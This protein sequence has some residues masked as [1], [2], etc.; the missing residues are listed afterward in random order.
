MMVN[1]RSII[2]FYCLP[3]LLP[4]MS[5]Q[6]CCMLLL[7]SPHEFGLFLV[8][9]DLLADSSFCMVV[10]SNRTLRRDA[11]WSRA[12]RNFRYRSA[13]GIHRFFLLQKW[14]RAAGLSTAEP[15]RYD[16]DDRDDRDDCNDRCAAA[17]SGGASDCRGHVGGDG[18]AKHDVGSVTRAVQNHCV[19]TDPK[20]A[21]LRLNASSLDS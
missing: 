2:C 17:Q 20:D 6:C 7:R 21:W 14:R 5:R 10:Y 1:G 18:E 9:L 19:F 12:H 8:S 15:S 13:G 4:T 16:R 3:L 11:P